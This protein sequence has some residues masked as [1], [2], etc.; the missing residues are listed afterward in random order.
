MLIR[1][2]DYLWIIQL[3]KQ[4]I[5]WLLKFPFKKYPDLFKTYGIL[6]SLSG[7]IQA[8]PFLFSLQHM[9]LPGALHRGAI[10]KSIFNCHINVCIS[11][12]PDSSQRQSW[13]LFLLTIILP[14]SGMQSMLNKLVIEFQFK[15]IRFKFGSTT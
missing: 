11:L 13:C 5:E 1:F 9:P 8:V 6:M 3:Y 12:L 7:L 2:M 4:V 10:L 15:S 14:E